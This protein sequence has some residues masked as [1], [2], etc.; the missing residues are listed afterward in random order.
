MSVGVG[1]SFRTGNTIQYTN[2]FGPVNL[3]VDIRVDDDEGPVDDDGNVRDGQGDGFGIG[4]VFHP[5]DNIS[6]GIAYDDS[7]GADTGTPGEPSGAETAEVPFAA[8]P[9]V[10]PFTP[11]VDRTAAKAAT[12]DKPDSEIFG[13]AAKA[14]FGN[15]WG[16]IGYQS[17]ETDSVDAIAG[18]GNTQDTHIPGA[19][20]VG[21]VETDWY[22]VWVG[23]NLGEKTSLAVGYGEQ[24]TE[25]D[26]NPNDVETEHF[27]IAVNHDMGGGLHFFLEFQDSSTETDGMEKDVDTTKTFLGMRLN[28]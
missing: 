8:G 23:T 24:E 7:D 9:P 27:A 15:F 17:Q 19:D 6:V 14:T 13:I 12:A 2:S 21:E 16:S 18:V 10:V 25:T 1:G 5:T 28:F 26:G 20:A 4:V 11:D 3:G 22:Q